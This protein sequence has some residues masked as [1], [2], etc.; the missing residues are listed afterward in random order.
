[1][2]C[3]TCYLEGT[4]HEVAE[5]DKIVSEGTI[6]LKEHGFCIGCAIECHD[7]HEIFEIG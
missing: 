4:G 5:F 7:G 3:K 6:K 2:A 1:M